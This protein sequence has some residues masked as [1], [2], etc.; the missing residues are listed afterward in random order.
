MVS[1]RVM[2]NRIAGSEIRSMM[3]RTFCLTYRV[4]CR[5]YVGPEMPP[6]LRTRQKCTIMKI[7]AMNGTPMQCRT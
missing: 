4:S 3:A 5:S 7:I 6:S 2:V 1:T